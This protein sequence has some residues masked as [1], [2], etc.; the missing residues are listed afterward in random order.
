MRGRLMRSR[1][2]MTMT[3]T[4]NDLDALR[5]FD[6]PTICNAL[7]LV[8]PERRAVGF[9]TRPLVCAVPDLPP[10]VGYARTATIRRRLCCRGAAPRWPRE[11]V[12]ASV[13]A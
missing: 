2:E 4:P 5:Q 12:H 9:T 6:T 10:I 1:M 7:E 3:P 13:S 8:A 11:P